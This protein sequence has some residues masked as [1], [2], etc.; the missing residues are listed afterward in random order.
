MSNA[1][2]RLVVAATGI[3]IVLGAVY[4][5][6]WWLFALLAAAAFL[7]LHEFW[8]LAKPLR[9]LSPAGYIGGDDIPR[10]NV[11]DLQRQI[12]ELREKAA[13]TSRREKP[14]PE[15]PQSDSPA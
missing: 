1:F 8:L 10:L 14:T 7:A 9:P 6:G 5:G 13:T 12:R 15:K 11:L 4:L 2:S 3:P